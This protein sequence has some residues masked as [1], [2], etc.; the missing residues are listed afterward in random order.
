MVNEIVEKNYQV[1]KT[2]EA[3]RKKAASCS[4]ALGADTANA[5]HAASE[6]SNLTANADYSDYELCIFTTILP[7]ALGLNAALSNTPSNFALRDSWVIDGASHV[8][9]CNMRDRF[10]S[11]EP[12][13]QVLPTGDNSTVIEGWGIS[14]A[15]ITKADGSKKKMRM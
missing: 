3:I 14:Y 2:V 4:G 11:I 7:E 10:E 6:A 15:W 1:R 9:V 5:L 13:H 8:H 12:C